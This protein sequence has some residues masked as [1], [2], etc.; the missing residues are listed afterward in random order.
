MSFSK[1]LLS[2][3]SLSTLFIIFTINGYAEDSNDISI[4]HKTA[5][6]INGI[7]FLGVNS[8][9]PRIISFAAVQN[10]TKQFKSAKLF[11]S[12]PNPSDNQVET[13]GDKEASL[14]NAKKIQW[15]NDFA[16]GEVAFIVDL[17]SNKGSSNSLYIPVGSIFEYYWEFV[18]SDNNLVR[19]ATY[20]FVFLDGQFKWNQ[21]GETNNLDLFFYGRED[22]D[23]INAY[24]AANDVINEAV[25]LLDIEIKFPIR[26]I[27]Y[28][29][30]DDASLAVPPKSKKF[31]EGTV[32]EGVKYRSDVVHRYAGNE[33]IIRHEITHIMTQ[34][35]GEGS[36]TKLPFWVDEG[37]AVYL[38][39]SPNYD[40]I[41]SDMIQ[42]DTVFRLS[43]IQGK[44]G[45]PEK[46]NA[47]YAQSYSVT[48]Y[49]IEEFGENKYKSFFQKLKADN[50]LEDALLQIY[51]YDQDSLYLAW[52]D[53]HKMPKVILEKLD[54]GNN[55]TASPVIKPLTTPRSLQ[56]G[57]KAL[58]KNNSTAE[59]IDSDRNSRPFYQ[60]T[61]SLAFLLFGALFIFGMLKIIKKL[62]QE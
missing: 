32:T 20:N 2:L 62:W 35:A 57:D 28:R 36:F 54:I 29:T 37:L 9:D 8:D 45:T 14:Q 1:I 51:N 49:L 21:I 60:N 5:D 31:S 38:M 53:F 23:I 48:K 25:N 43:S 33:S 50:G 19:T 4:L 13:L 44:P 12:L 27:Y 52:R 59:K 34:I 58:S 41:I 56:A 61:K 7:T 46:V 26:I 16:K 55:M 15:L 6:P 30:P 18:D 3:L 11:Y 40:F 42:R 22:R 17:D 39:D 10:E 24:F 47:F